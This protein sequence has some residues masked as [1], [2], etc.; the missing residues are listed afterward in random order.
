MPAANNSSPATAIAKTI[1]VMQ[2]SSE[3]S[4]YIANEHDG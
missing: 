2:K 1:R 4:R 3:D